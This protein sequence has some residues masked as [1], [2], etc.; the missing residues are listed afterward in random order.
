MPLVILAIVLFVFGF[1]LIMA[2]PF[3]L[4]W[5]YAVVSALTCAKPIGFWVAYWLMVFFGF[6]LGST[7][8]IKTK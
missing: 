7:S 3:M 5:N 6:F 1:S 8:Q 4:I 2:F